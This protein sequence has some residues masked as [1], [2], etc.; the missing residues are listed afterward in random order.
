MIREIVSFLLYFDSFGA[1]LGAN[2]FADVSY[3]ALAW[4]YVVLYSLVVVTVFVLKG[5]GLYSLSKIN[6]IDKPYLSFIPFVSFYQLGRL[7]GS[8]SVFR[9]KIKNLGIIVGALLFVTVVFSNIIEFFR[10][11]ET[12]QTILN[13]NSFIPVTDAKGYI[14]TNETV[15]L[16][17][18]YYVNLVISLIE[19]LL[20]I[21]LIIPF[22][23]FYAKRSALVFAILSIFIDP[24]F[25]IFVFV[26]R[27]NKKGSFYQRPAFGGQPYG[28]GYG[29]SDPFNR[30]GNPYESG[31]N[32]GENRGFTATQNTGSPFEEYKKPENG[33]VFEEYSNNTTAQN[34]KKEFKP[35]DKPPRND[36]DDDLF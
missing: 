17:I 7:V 8:V 14:I 25:G 9:T 29:G 30:S 12:L 22:F 26:V 35:Y 28:G 36:D 3:E 20:F 21:F 11:F 1:Y 6:G 23:R 31:Q 18:L 13:S 24:L 16:T 33:D 2:A 10:Y 27:K 4:L 15:L 32:S 19:T 5:I 34:E